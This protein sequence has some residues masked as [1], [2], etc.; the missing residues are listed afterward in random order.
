MSR[1]DGHNGCPCRNYNFKAQL[2][3]EFPYICLD[4]HVQFCNMVLFRKSVVNMGIRLQQG[5]RAYKK[6]LDNLESFK[7]ELKSFLL[8]HAYSLDAF[9]L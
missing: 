6:K 7:R 2:F 8:H 9:L 4:L 5:A 1:E 3:V